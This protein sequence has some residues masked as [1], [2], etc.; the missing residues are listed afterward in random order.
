VVTHRA[1]RLLHPREVGPSLSTNSFP[2]TRSLAFSHRDA[3]ATRCAALATKHLWVTPFQRDE[4]FPAGDHPNQRPGGAGLPDW[5]KANCQIEDTD[6]VLWYSLSGY[7]VTRPEDWPVMPVERVGFMLKPAGF[8]D[9][10]PALDV[11]PGPSRHY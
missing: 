1:D 5:M 8:F 9:R 2:A 11:T 3:S 4:R 6:A 7:H 10:N